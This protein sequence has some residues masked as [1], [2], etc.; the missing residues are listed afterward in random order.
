MCIV[1]YSGSRM[2]GECEG[3]PLQRMYI[4]DVY[5]KILYKHT[6]GGVKQN[7]LR[8]IYCIQYLVVRMKERLVILQLS[9]LVS[10]NRRL[11]WSPAICNSMLTLSNYIFVF[12]LSNNSSTESQWYR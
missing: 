11:F 1:R 7:S 4:S 6:S 3:G 10:R 9:I 2:E 5:E 12:Y 8:L